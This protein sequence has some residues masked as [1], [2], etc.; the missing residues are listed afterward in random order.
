MMFHPQSPA[1]IPDEPEAA[2][3]A[4]HASHQA[5][6]TCGPANEPGFTHLLTG[7]LTALP[8]TFPRMLEAAD[9]VEKAV[10][11]GTDR[12]YVVAPFATA[13]ELLVL[14]RALANPWES[15]DSADMASGDGDRRLEALSRLADD[16][17]DATAFE[18]AVAKAPSSLPG[19]GVVGEWPPMPIDDAGLLDCGTSRRDG[20]THVLWVD[21][22]AVPGDLA[23]RVAGLPGV[24]RVEWEGT[25]LLHLEAHGAT[26]A[27]L[28]AEARSVARR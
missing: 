7:D 28:L 24:A 19:R 17:G 5:F 27:D 14:A 3:D 22:G 20:F 10:A 16:F 11:V 9:G 21:R 26:H 4:P 18:P 6:A 8:A 13:D 12:L 2:A 15:A 1:W 25:E 23:E